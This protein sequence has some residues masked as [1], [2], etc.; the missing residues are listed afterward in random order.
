MKTELQ[1]LYEKMIEDDRVP[2]EYLELL[3]ELIHRAE[4][5]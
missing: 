4:N 2:E 5:K 3:E 1:D